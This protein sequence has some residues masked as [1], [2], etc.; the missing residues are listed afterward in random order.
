M[1]LTDKGDLYYL[2]FGKTLMNIFFVCGS[3]SDFWIYSNAFYVMI[4]TNNGPRFFFG[5]NKDFEQT[6]K[7]NRNY[8]E[9]ILDDGKQVHLH[10]LI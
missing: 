10:E 3:V 1:A 7:R 5:N 6:L 8:S 9:N 4:R 2:A